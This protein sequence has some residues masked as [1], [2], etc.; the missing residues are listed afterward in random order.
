MKNSI[1]FSD[2]SFDNLKKKKKWKNSYQNRSILLFWPKNSRIF[3]SQMPST[4][5]FRKVHIIGLILKNTKKVANLNC[6]QNIWE[7]KIML[8]EEAI[9]Q[10]YQE[11]WFGPSPVR[12]EFGRRCGKYWK[13]DTQ[14]ELL[15]NKLYLWRE[16]KN[17]FRTQWFRLTH[18][19]MVFTWCYLKDVLKGV[20]YQPP[21]IRYYMLCIIQIYMFIICGGYCHFL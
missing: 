17:R 6:C 16:E 7:K 19:A 13:W 10:G 3:S 8:L 11:S 2:N 20:C 4:A 12:T 1:S 14:L 15:G 18:L 5:V 9:Y 21:Q